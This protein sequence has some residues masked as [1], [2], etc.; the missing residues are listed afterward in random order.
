M[1]HFSFFFVIQAQVITWAVRKIAAYL[2]L[3]L[4]H[5]MMYMWNEGHIYKTLVKFAAYGEI[6][7]R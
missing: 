5:H 7:D 4:V 2:Y 3:F 6:S 1:S